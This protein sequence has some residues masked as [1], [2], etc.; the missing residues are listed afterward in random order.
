VSKRNL[1]VI[2]DESAEIALPDTIVG[3][4]VRIVDWRQVG[5]QSSIGDD[6]VLIDID[7]HDL[8][9]LEVVK[10]TLSH[11]AGKQCRIIAI[12]R[13][14]HHSKLQANSLGAS[15][16]IER[17][18]DIHDLKAR[19]KRHFS[20][21][22]NARDANGKTEQRPLALE[23]GASSIGSAAAALNAIFT[24]A[25]CGGS[26]DLASVAHAGDAVIDA[27][28]EIGIAK[29][30]GMVR[31][32]HHSTFQH[33]LI[34]TGV[35]TAFGH[36]TGMRRSDVLTLTVAGLL[37]DIGKGQIPIEILDKPGKL[38]S[39]EF[40]VIKRHPRIGYDYLRAEKN[41]SS[42][43]LDAV[44]H[45][46]EYLDGSGYPDQLQGQQIGD[47]TRILTV[48]DTYG[49]LVEQR[50]Y[51]PA[52]SPEVAMDILADMARNGKVEYGLVRALS[53]LVLTRS[54]TSL[55]SPVN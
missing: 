34:V 27:I 40:T 55:S 29:W 11:W 8:S 41:I 47:L 24:A 7:L 33:C 9:K 16:F 23:L 20:Q 5:E 51:K 53:K 18:L 28:A 46:H 3:F 22:R 21:V 39:E 31:N 1:I 42:D 52:N 25:N 12:E 30:I 10:T 49:A 38:T 44:L 14:S 50:A 6:A 35:S 48:C 17:P 43:I 45:H 2:A 32:Y 13:C 19:L 15:D 4:P 36:G 54:P 37:H 26:L